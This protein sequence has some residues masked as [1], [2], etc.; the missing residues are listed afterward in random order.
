MSKASAFSRVSPQRR[1]HSGEEVAMRRIERGVLLTLA[2]ALAVVSRAG[3]DTLH[4]AADAQTSS[5]QPTLKLGLLP[6]RQG[7]SGPVY[8]N[9]ARFDLSPLPDDAT[10]QKAT[11]RLRV[12]AVVTS[13]TIEVV[14]I[15]DTWDEGTITAAASP[16]LG[17]PA[18]SFAVESGDTLHFV[19]VDVTGLVRD[20]ATGLLDNHGLALRGVA[21]GAVN[22]VLDTKVLG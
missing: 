2:V 5:A 16:V 9:Y 1:I 15:F 13:G 17:T 6:A 7:A 18:A 21:G 20:W 11:L 22:V 19:D 8:N 12:L 3:A 10:V 14:P 4:V